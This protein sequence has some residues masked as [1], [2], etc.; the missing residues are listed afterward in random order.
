MIISRI[1]NYD[2]NK[3]INNWWIWTEKKTLIHITH[4]LTF[5]CEMCNNDLSND[6][7]PIWRYGT[8]AIDILEVNKSVKSNSTGTDGISL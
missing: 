1:V 5:L 8:T 3:V 4:C 7:D 6:P 2:L